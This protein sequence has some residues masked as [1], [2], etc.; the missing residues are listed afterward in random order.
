MFK[1]EAVKKLL[2]DFNIDG[3]FQL[4]FNPM[5]NAELN[6]SQ[7]LGIP[8]TYYRFLK[9]EHKD[10][11]DYNITELFS[12]REKPLFVRTFAPN[13]GSDE[14]ML[15]AVLSDRYKVIDHLD[16]LTATLDAIKR[17]DVKVDIGR[18]NLTESSMYVEFYSKEVEAD[19]KDFI[20]RYRAPNGNSG[21]GVLAGFIISNSEVGSGKYR[22]IPRVVWTVCN[23]GMIARKDAMEHTHLGSKMDGGILWSGETKRKELELILS[24][25]ED[26]VSTFLSPDYLGGLME[27]LESHTEKLDNPIPAVQNFS[28]S[29]GFSDKERNRILNHFIDS[30]DF[31]PI[32]AVQAVTYEAQHIENADMQYEV[33]EKAFDLLPTFR[34]RFEIDELVVTN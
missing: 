1:E 9:E 20:R 33:E 15:R 8:M 4:K 29:L 23:N 13:N 22:I 16:V 5:A 3:D 18:C 7:K 30:G 17:A 32:G 34:D 12:R 11:L 25:V 14:G 19:V 2:S 21:G 10:M 31:S 6:M 27:N 26:A 28:T 24:Q